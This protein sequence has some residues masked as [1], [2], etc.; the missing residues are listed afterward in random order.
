MAFSRFMQVSLNNFLGHAVNIKAITGNTAGL[1]KLTDMLYKHFC[2]PAQ[3]LLPAYRDSFQQTLKALRL[4]LNPPLISWQCKVV[5]DFQQDIKKL[6]LPVYPHKE[7][8]KKLA[9]ECA[10]LEQHSLFAQDSLHIGTKQAFEADLAG[11]IGARQ[12][13]D[14][15]QAIVND[16]QRSQAISP[17][18]LNLLQAQDLLACGI[19]HF[20]RADKN[21]SALISLLQQ[22]QTFQRVLIIDENVQSILRLVR[23]IH[24]YAERAQ[25]N[26]ADDHSV[27]ALVQARRQLS[28]QIDSPCLSTLTRAFQTGEVEHAR[29]LMQQALSEARNTAE[30]ALTHYSLFKLSSAEHQPDLAEAFTHLQAAIRLDAAH[31]APCD[32]L[33]FSLQALLGV[34]GMGYALLAQAGKTPV[35][36][37][38]FWQNLQHQQLDEALKI[39]RVAQAVV[40]PLFGTGIYQYH[41]RLCL[42]SHYL[43]HA[44]D[45]ARWLQTQGKLT[46]AQ[47]LTVA[48]RLAEAL[49]AIHQ[50]G[51]LHLDLKPANLLLL[52]APESA[53]W[54]VRIIDF[55][56]SKLLPSLATQN[57][58]RSLT[59]SLARKITASFEYAAPEQKSGLATSPAS[60]VYSYAK[61]M[62]ELLGD[63]NGFDVPLGLQKILAKCLKAKPE[64][65]I[66]LPDLLAELADLAILASPEL[67]T[68]LTVEEFPQYELNPLA[69]TIEAP[70]LFAVTTALN[71]EVAGVPLELVYIPEG[72]FMMGAL[73]GDEDELPVQ[74]VRI[75]E[76]FYMGKFP[77]TQRQYQAVMG[78]NPSHWKEED[79]PVEQVSWLDAC[80][81]CEHLSQ[82][83]DRTFRLPTEAEWE[84]ACRAGTETAFSFGEIVSTERANYDGSYGYHGGGKG[85]YRKRTTPVGRFPP[86]AFG[87]YDMHGNVWEWTC[88]EYAP[89]R[90]KKAMLCNSSPEGQRVLRGGSWFNLPEHMR[91]SHRNSEGTSNRYYYIGFRI[92]SPA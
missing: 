75:S 25:N 71:F 74:R 72:E 23:D 78:K 3:H 38:C 68:P 34:G 64:A 66:K 57:H 55:G 40:P 14:L 5:K 65:R 30:Q 80:A 84:Y 76:G 86:N 13:P 15:T 63:I 48:I 60:D 29:E 46:D 19:W 53:A 89:Y 37:K 27:Q 67:I 1:N 18:L 32:P 20:L 17:E 49:H 70:D 85:V 51:V 10:R 81:F 88:S 12:L 31:Y 41:G 90:D 16:I 82:R 24:Q 28:H 8:S 54:Q 50:S 92:V 69:V 45:G 87:L 6:F 9:R 62:L 56:L 7:L 83:L 79:S 58:T 52:P 43:P 59:G 77:I 39:Q 91:S 36:M 61:T 11:L 21:V 47:G 73:D 22:E 4:T 35:V 33:S 26:Y 2:Q 42:V 44:I